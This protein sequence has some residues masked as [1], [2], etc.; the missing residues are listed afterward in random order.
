MDIIE[1]FTGL[2]IADSVNDPDKRAIYLHNWE[3][4]HTNYGE[5]VDWE[6]LRKQILLCDET[7]D[8]LYR[9][10]KP[11]KYVRGTRPYLDKVV[12]EVTAN[13]TTDKE[14]ILSIFT[15]IRDLYKKHEA[16][17]FIQLFYGGTEEDLIKKGENLCECVARLMVALCEVAGFPGR[18]ILQIVAGHLVSE[19]YFDGKW[20]FFDPRGGIFYLDA[21]DNFLSIREIMADR[22]VIFK[23]K[24]WVKAYASDLWTHDYWAQKNYDG[25]MHPNEMPCFGEYSL[26]DADEYHFEWIYTN[27]AANNGLGECIARYGELRVPVFGKPFSW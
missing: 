5:N 8:Y 18:I 22:S 24:D 3:Q 27:I 23:Q 13:C 1:K 9:T 20:A 14:K 21:D 12:D 11:V 25:S 17:T 4:M 10:P 2:N 6:R 7:A 15:Y 19:I 26:M 16:G